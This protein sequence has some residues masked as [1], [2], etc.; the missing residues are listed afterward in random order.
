MRT[1]PEPRDLGEPEDLE[2]LMVQLPANRDRTAD[3]TGLNTLLFQRADH[4]LGWLGDGRKVTSTG[5]L[6]LADTRELM[7]ELGLPEFGIRTM[8]EVPE[9]AG[10]WGVLLGSGFVL[11]VGTRAIRNEN[12]PERVDE[13]SGSLEEVLGYRTMFHVAALGAVLDPLGEEDFLDNPVHTFMALVKAALPGGVPLP[14]VD[15]DDPDGRSSLLTRVDLIRLGGMGLVTID[16]GEI[17]HCPEVLLPIL[18]TLPS[19]FSEALEDADY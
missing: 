15:L 3:A 4:I 8:W 13:N 16:E 10:P 9:I 11:W 19:R 17:V 14:P 7:A 2:D 5:A 12:L 6:P 1:F 18:L